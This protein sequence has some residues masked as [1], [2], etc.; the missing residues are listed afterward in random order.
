M[1]PAFS[2]LRPWSSVLLLLAFQGGQISASQTTADSVPAGGLI[3]ANPQAAYTFIGNDFLGRT[4]GLDEA[5]G[6]RTGGYLVPDFD[7]VASGGVEPNG[8]FGSI[9]L[10]LHA[11]VDTQKTLAIPGGTWGVEF[12]VSEGGA[13]NNAAGSVQL[14]TNMTAPEPID[15]QEMT[16]LWWHQRLFNDR[17]IFQIGKMNGAGHFN[18]VLK[19]VIVSEPHLQDHTI[20]DLIYVPVGLNPTLFARLP[21]YPDTAFGAVAHLAPT[22]DLYVS[23]GIFDGN[24]AR[25]VPTGNNWLPDIN[26]Y[27]FN[28]AEVGYSWRLGRAGMP[29]RIG[30]GNWWQ[31]GELYTPALT[32]EDGVTGY[33]LFANQRLWYRHPS[34]DNS[35]LIG[36]LQFGHT[37]SETSIVN[38]YWGAGF[39]G[40]DLVPGRPWDTLNFGLAFS[41]LND[42]PGA[43]AFF[44]PD[45]PSNSSDLRSS[46]LMLQ[47]AYQGNFAFGTPANYWTLSAIL[48][49]TYIPTP[50][51]R[52]DL[53]AASVLSARL[54]VL[55]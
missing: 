43:G 21:N 46:E 22:T 10:G 50:G 13:N 16:Q 30:L 29:G 35:G 51:Q 1:T 2:I 27:R 31:T 47:A 3:L 45:V 8:T 55:F 42:T 37:G 17:L 4:L 54:V 19:P 36:Y 53:P 11:S 24:A 15:R 48:A 44:Y 32:T 9:A 41:R 49:Y 52:P 14:Y 23:Y 7:W 38:T 34:L 26:D 28:I 5:S 6:L 39:T 12:L 20:S 40:I 33:Y 18:T 25:G